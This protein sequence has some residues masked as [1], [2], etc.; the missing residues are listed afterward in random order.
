VATRGS[1]SRGVDFTVRAGVEGEDDIRALAGELR[2]VGDA[3]GGAAPDVAALARQLD[4]LATATK[5]KREA[6]AAARTE[7]T[8]A[9]RAL[10]EQRDALARMRAGSDA[11]TRA[12]AEHQAAERALRLAV[13]EAG[14]ALRE[15]QR[16]LTAASDQAKQAAA[17]EARLS[18]QIER[19]RRAAV[20]GNTAVAD[21]VGSLSA[22][23]ATLRNVVGAIAG[24]TLVGSL[25]RDVAATADAYT[26]LAAKI[27]LTTG[28]GEA[29]DRAF[30]GVQ[31][32][33]LR[34]GSALESTGTLF[35]RIAEAGKLIGVSQAQALALTETITQAV[36][37]SGTAAAGSEAALQ[38]LIQ[39]LQS[40]VLRGEEF[41]SVME[42]APRLAR[43]LADG[44]GVTTGELRKQAEAGRL[45]SEVVIKALQGQAQALQQEFSKLPPTVGRALQ[46]LSTQW[47]VY[48]GEVDKSTGASAAA[49]QAIGFL[50]KHLNELG[51]V[52]LT[53]GEAFAAVKALDLAGAFLRQATAV[54]AG[55][56]ATAANTAATAGNTAATAANANAKATGAAATAAGATALAS[57]TTATV[58]NTAAT[59][60]NT[61]AAAAGA[62]GMLATLGTLARFAGGIG[63]AVTA[64]TLLWDVV[65]KGVKFLGTA[66]GEGAAKLQGFRDRTAE[67]AEAEEANAR[68]AAENARQHA[69]AV[70]QME[71][72]REA[73]LGLT[74]AAQQ[75]IADFEGMRAKG[76]P[77]AEA[78]EGLAKALD[79]GDLTGFQAAGAALDTLEQKGK[80]SAAGVRDAWQQALKG[81][82]LLRFETMA[83][84]AFDGSAQGARRLQAVLDAIADESLRRFGTSSEEFATGFTK[85]TTSA[86]NDV[87]ILARTLRDLKAPADDAGRVL[88]AALD[89]ALTTANTDRAVQALIDRIK[90]LGAEGL[91]TGDRLAQALQN[92]QAKLDDLKPGVSS[93]SE[94]LR[95]F[96]LQ[97]REEL[98]RTADKLGESYR[99]ISSSADVSL[100]QQIEAYGRWRT[101]A[102]A[103]SKG[104]E[105]GHLAEQRTILANRAAVAGLGDEYERAMG[106]AERATRRATDA[107]Q[108]QRNA[109]AGSLSSSFDGAS[110]ARSTVGGATYDQEGW[111]T[112]ADGSRITAGTQLQPPDNSGNWTF[113]SDMSAN[114]GEQTVTLPNGRRVS[115]RG[116]PGVG[117]WVRTDGGGGLAIRARNG[118]PGGGA[119]QGAAAGLGVTSPAPG[120]AAGSR[121]A[122]APAF[123]PQPVVINISGLPSRTVN[124]ASLADAQALQDLL[125]GLAQGASTAAGG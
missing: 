125:R 67:L 7:A 97:S 19:T 8:A 36:A 46:N 39:G 42:Q 89:K 103:A 107:L 31:D 78:I 123:T 98:Q 62:R 115:G 40:G 61:A 116:V 50:A 71:R 26:S 35:A 49:A 60:A 74:P 20:A 108:E 70:Q 102:L 54:Q 80:L 43:A 44:L 29:F 59:A 52:L 30:Q 16:A 121:G 113:V 22:Q 55:T 85:A 88:Q 112:N 83:R 27:R 114:G 96:G 109:M 1:N 14:I 56:V 81:D 57:A 33:A 82:D 117:Y 84:A 18:D 122:E 111:A 63:L 93:L 120:P 45:S 110:Q 13:V 34:T 24:G 72:A 94:A 41:N 21:S 95:N 79:L 86:I 48:V 66:I 4:G 15:K 38:Q 17:A 77:A 23:L 65:A 32:V 90:A 9:R 11:A 101:A 37:V 12:T 5:A 25:A 76:K 100:Q 118:L 105:S 3:A 92:A 53:A 47:T 91:L 28:E 119:S 75:L 64:V 2:G 106:R 124:V 69:A 51:A 58:A 68:A 87:D 73:A 10:E 99:V 6:E 104:V